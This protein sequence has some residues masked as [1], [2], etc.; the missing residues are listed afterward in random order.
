MG[1]NGGTERKMIIK[2]VE[3]EK[4]DK[5]MRR[6]RKRNVTEELT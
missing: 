1:Q 3:E 6:R 5:E 4:G 2:E